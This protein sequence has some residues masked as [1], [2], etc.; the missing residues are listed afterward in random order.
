MVAGLGLGIDGCGEAARLINALPWC[1]MNELRRLTGLL[2]HAG[3]RR[4]TGLRVLSQGGDAVVQVGMAAYILF[5][6]QSQANAWAVAMVI[7]LI[8]VPFSV[9]GP[10]VSPIL[11]RFWRQRIV[12][13]ADLTRVLMAAMIAVLVG[14]N[15][16]T[17]GWQ[18]VLLVSLI[19][20]LSLNR[21]Q[22]AALTAGM[23]HTVARNEYLSASSI[24]PMIGPAAAMI[25]G[26][27]AGAVRLLTG[28]LLTSGWVDGLI[29]LIAALMF[30]AGIVV[31]SRFGRDE[32][33]PVADQP[34]SSWAQVW[35]G[36]TLAGR[37]LWRAR[38]AFT[39]VMMVLG[40]R[41]GYGVLMTAVIV[42]Y[43]HHFGSPADLERVMLE[44]G[45]WF[46]LSGAG[47]ALSG[48]VAS[49]ISA[50]IGVRATLLAM[51]LSA[52]VVLAFPGALL[53]RPALLVT[54][55]I[56]GLA[57][58]SV[59]ICG[60]TLVQAHISDEVRGRVVVIYDIINNLGLAIGAVIGALVLPADGHSVPTMI[61][62]SVGFLVCAAAFWLTSRGQSASYD[63][64][65][66]R[67]R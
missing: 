35:S 58:Q 7:A 5:S 50:K 34:R 37:E 19:T 65:T 62:L 53:N 67:A 40:A 28:R 31:S 13:I 51:Y 30:T 20:M 54:G 8:T 66:A 16:V 46:L 56:V 55:F 11:D 4:L 6:P 47:F 32:L 48:L 61:G 2:R 14:T 9:V 29:F 59:K 44:M 22:L 26:L 25:G 24:M 23:P 43:R 21:L 17:G 39:G 63:Q 60:D 38:P 18:G 41:I 27:L 49:P 12:I 64:G 33:G 52:S 1:D 45:G 42:L 36:L 15:H 57:F 10:F 3:F